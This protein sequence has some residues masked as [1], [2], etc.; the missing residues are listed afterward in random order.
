MQRAKE[1]HA[2]S[3]TLYEKEIRRARKEAFKSSS[4]L[5]KLQE[6]LKTARNRFTLMREEVEVQKRKV[7]AKEQETFA[8]QYQ[9][10]GVQEELEKTKQDVTLVTEENTALKTSLKEEEIARIAAEGSIALPVSAEADEFASPQREDCPTCQDLHACRRGSLKENVDPVLNKLPTFDENEL[11]ILKRK[12]KYEIWRRKDAEEMVEHLQI[13]CQFKVCSCRLA[14]RD[15]YEYI[16]DRSVLDDRYKERIAQLRVE[17][18]GTASQYE[19]A[20]R[21]SEDTLELPK[22]DEVDIGK[23]IMEESEPENNQETREDLNPQV[24]FSPTTGTFHTVP[25]PTHLIHSS[26]SATPS[27]PSPSAPTTPFQNQHLA[28]SLDSPTDQENYHIDPPQISFPST[29]R[30]PASSVRPQTMR[31]ISTTTTVPLA[32]PYSPAC[33]MTREEALE[34]IRHRRGRARSVALNGTPRKPLT[35]PAALRRDISAPAGTA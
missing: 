31:V 25:S 10:V 21:A 4:A 8:A 27:P 18:N 3:Q 23:A 34:Q 16:H 2:R 1:T 6:D 28:S 19:L 9:L 11:T 32:E 12:L 15:G 22:G 7:E 14:E 5:V 29:P 30:P 20:T 17:Q 13:E 26:N 33:T 35:G 24:T